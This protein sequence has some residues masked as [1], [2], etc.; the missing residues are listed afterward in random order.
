[1]FFGGTNWGYNTGCNVFLPVQTSYDYDAPVDEA[2]RVTEKYRA[3]RDLF[4]KR[5]GATPP[6]IPAD[7]P[8]AALPAISLDQHEALLDWLPAAPT[9]TSVKPVSMENLDQDYGFV[10]YRKKFPDGIKG[11]LELREAMDYTIVL[12]NGKNVGESF[13]GLD[14][15]TNTIDLNESGPV[16]LDLLVHDMGRLSVPVSF[17]TQYIARK[18]LVGGA[19]L[20]GSELTGWDI[21][22]LPLDHVDNFKSSDAAPVGPVF[23]HGSFNV[24]QPVSTFLDMRK[25]SFGVVWVNGHNLGR[26]W[27][28][29]GLRTLFLS[30]HFLHGGAND[31]TL[32][33][34]QKAPDSSVI[35][36]SD[37]IIDEGAIPF[38]TRLDPRVVPPAPTTPSTTP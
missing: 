30:S 37:K 26:Y 25:W 7:P 21:Y 12:A 24:D 20:D 15:P 11:K 2:G 22:S 33:E 3:L 8:V 17:Q 31:I 14:S 29:G 38:P 1:M 23:Y 32:L 5:L 9:I 6:E 13:P 4:I 35:P 28:R 16:T 18:G 36:C 19:F 27:N 34:L 10:L